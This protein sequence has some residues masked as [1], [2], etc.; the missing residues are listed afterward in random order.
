[1]ILLLTLLVW[2]EIKACVPNPF[3]LIVSLM[4][5]VFHIRNLFCKIGNTGGGS[6]Q[7]WDNHL[8]RNGRQGW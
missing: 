7:I 4:T 8:V 2:I 6:V 5:R 1:M 3:I